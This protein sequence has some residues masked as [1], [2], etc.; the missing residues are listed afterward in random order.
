MNAA[1][2]VSSPLVTTGQKFRY[3]LRIRRLEFLPVHLSVILTAAFLGA[4]SADQLISGK[5]LAVVVAFLLGLHAGNM[6]NCVADRELDLIY[7]GRL[8]EAVD[9]LGKRNIVIQI[10][11]HIVLVLLLGAYVTASSGHWEIAV[12]GVVWIVV[13]FEYSLPPLRLK[14]AGVFQSVTLASTIALLPGIMMIRAIGTVPEW[15]AFVAFLGYTTAMTMVNLINQTEDIPE[16]AK[17][18]IMTSARALGLTGTVTTALV[19]VVIGAT[20]FLAAAVSLGAYWWAVGLYAVA[21]L[22]TLRFISGIL[23]GVRGK[24]LDDAI[25]IARKNTRRLPLYGAVMG[26]GSVALAV[27]VFAAR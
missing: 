6:A 25:L 20:T 17:F 24:S 19:L 4:A 9:G 10:V 16:D 22:F 18:G 27:A 8:A 7:K 2:S 1:Q 3:A 12:L 26:W 5:T 15:A 21:A 23:R 14:G 11:T 13:G